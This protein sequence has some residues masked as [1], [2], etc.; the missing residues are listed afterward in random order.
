MKL[1]II[2]SDNEGLKVLW[3]KCLSICKL[4]AI[5]FWAHC[6]YIRSFMAQT[7][8]QLECATYTIRPSPLTPTCFNSFPGQVHCYFECARTQANAYSS[9]FVIVDLKSQL[10]HTLWYYHHQLQW[11][12]HRKWDANEHDKH[13]M[14]AQN[15]LWT[16]SRH[17]IAR[18]QRRSMV[19]LLWY[20]WTKLT[21]F[22]QV[23]NNVLAL[24]VSNLSLTIHNKTHLKSINQLFLQTYQ[25]SIVNS[26]GSTIRE[27]QTF[28]QNCVRLWLIVS[29]DMQESNTTHGFTQ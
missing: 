2:G 3:I 9:Y 16:H 10:Q 21:S 5:L 27:V 1:V 26:I 11:S 29:L 19:R 13:T 6:I 7:S 24:A 8:Y 4:S 14:R 20:F 18:P 23:L 17:P 25:P 12:L 28:V 22:N 15:T